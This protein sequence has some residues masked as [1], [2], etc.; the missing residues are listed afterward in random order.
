MK[1]R[2]LSVILAIIMIAALTTPAF[3]APVTY[4]DVDT[5]H[6]AH[7]YI[8][9]CFNKGVMTGNGDGTFSP[10]ANTTRAELAQMLFNYSHNKTF[11]N[12]IVALTDVIY[13]AWYTQATNWAVSNDLIDVAF[14]D[15]DGLAYFYPDTPATREE[16]VNAFY[17][18]KILLN[19][20]PIQTNPAINFPDVGHLEPASLDALRCMSESGIV[21]GDPD[22]SFRPDDPVI[23]AEV[24]TIVDR[25]TDNYVLATDPPPSDE[26]LVTEAAL[27]TKQQIETYAESRGFRMSNYS[28]GIRIVDDLRVMAT[29]EI[30]FS[31]DKHLIKIEYSNYSWM[32]TIIFTYR[33]HLSDENFNGIIEQSNSGL[34]RM[35]DIFALLDKYS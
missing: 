13:P 30:S 7:D 9:S 28:T 23:R 26:E 33:V 14:V 4:T 3:A 34:A 31:R 18:L 25:Y 10:D 5:S 20:V 15:D 12:N 29:S 22:G 6:W 2:L 11:G 21:K 1:K 32:S 17:Q 24:A 16:I 27:N 19:L 35:N 8:M